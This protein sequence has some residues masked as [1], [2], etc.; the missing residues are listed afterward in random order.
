MSQKRLSMRKVRD[1]L[2]L[3]YGLGRSHREIAGML[4]ISHSTVGDYVRRAREAGVSW[5]LPE[6]LDDG[7][8]ESALYCRRSPAIGRPSPSWDR[9]DSS[10]RA[11]T[12]WAPIWQ[13]R[14]ILGMDDA[15][16]V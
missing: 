7:A 13:T 14:E 16:D 1:V 9:Q 4:G 2:R 15:G 5:P 10:G 12:S 8:L 6:G 11:S 3:K